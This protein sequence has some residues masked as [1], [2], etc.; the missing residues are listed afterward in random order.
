[1]AVIYLFGYSLN[2]LSLMALII[3]TGFVV[4]DAIVV[5]E[6]VA[7][8]IENGVPPFEAALRGVREVGFTVV[9][10]SLSLVAVFVPLLFMGGVVG[11]LFREFAVT[12]AVAVLLSMLVSLMATPMLCSRLLRAPAPGGPR[13]VARLLERA[14]AIPL[15]GYAR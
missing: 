13:R 15:A 14:V 9:A 12:L 3:S 8:H 11:R 10:M 4:D 2:N 5:V 6:N 7:H 1:L